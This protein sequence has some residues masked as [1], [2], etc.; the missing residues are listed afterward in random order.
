MASRAPCEIRD[1][2]AS[3]VPAVVALVREVLSEFGLVFGEGCETD[4]QLARLPGSYVEAGGRFWVAVRD[5]A[6][7]GTCGVFPV[8][9]GALELR[10]M[11]LAPAAR[12]LG[13][14]K[15]LL[16]AAVAHARASGAAHLVLDT[17]ERME[18]ARAFY[19]AHGFVRD[20]AQVRGARCTRGYRLDLGR[21]GSARR[22]RPL[23][24]TG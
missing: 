12:G 9:P 14:G 15:A 13:I 17:I 22:G 2:A 19:E 5:G 21:G 10:K 3:D 16:E 8:A 20:D 11:Y 1:V 7:L 4:A 23:P 18:A 24:G 6:L